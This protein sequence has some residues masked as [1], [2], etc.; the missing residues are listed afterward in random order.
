ML[1][2]LG[3]VNPVR[4]AMLDARP[5][6]EA[7]DQTAME[8]ALRTL[9]RLAA[10]RDGSRAGRLLHVTADVLE[11]RWSQEPPSSSSSS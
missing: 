7:L 6:T 10:Q 4:R 2:W 1:A 11:R 8:E 5:T 3:V 9:R